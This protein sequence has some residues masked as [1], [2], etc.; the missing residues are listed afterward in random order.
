M[1]RELKL[2]MPLREKYTAETRLYEERRRADRMSSSSR[3]AL[4]SYLTCAL[5]R[6]SD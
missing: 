3:L 1:F 4:Q 2:M 5:G 6:V